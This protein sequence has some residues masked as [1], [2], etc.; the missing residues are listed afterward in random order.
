VVVTSL[1]AQQPLPVG[2]TH[3]VFVAEQTGV[4]SIRAAGSDYDCYFDA[5]TLFTRHQWPIHA[6]DL[7]AGEPIEVVADR[8]PG[9]E[10]C[11]ARIFAVVDPAP[12]PGRK[13]AV[14][15]EPLTRAPRGYLTFAGLVTNMTLSRITMTTRSGPV[16]LALRSDTTYSDDGVRLASSDAATQTLVNKHVFVRAGKNIY[17]TIEAYQVMWGEILEAR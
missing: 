3:G 4:V 7:T 1:Q 8:R 10:V 15:Q 13:K 16:T 11:Y 2:I 12:P 6:M 17:G 9:T 14:S 5:H